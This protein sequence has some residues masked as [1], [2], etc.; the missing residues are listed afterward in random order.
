M[1]QILKIGVISPDVVLVKG[2]L[3][4]HGFWFGDKS[5]TYTVELSH[6]VAKFQQ[7]HSN[8]SGLPCSVDGNV[9]QE[10][11]WALHNASGE[12]QGNALFSSDIPTGISGLRAK[13]LQVALAQCGIKEIPDGSNRGNRPNGGV[14]KFLPDW[15]KKPGEKGP[16]WCCFYVSWVTNEAFGKYPLGKRIG[17]CK[18]A[19]GVAKSLGMAYTAPSFVVPGDAFIMMHDNVAGHTGFVYYVNSDG[20]EFNTIEGNCGNMVKIGKRCAKDMHGFINFYGDSK[21]GFERKLIKS[22][23]VGKDGTR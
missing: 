14:D 10:T 7:T 12:Q 21:I 8:S 6:A 1:N 3:H 22:D 16:P 2:I 13:I 20:S 23:D 18:E 15:V 9:G 17:S 19:Y 5:S 4:A 11:W